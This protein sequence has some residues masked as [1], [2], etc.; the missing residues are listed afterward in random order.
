MEASPSRI[1]VMGWIAP[2]AAMAVLSIAISTSHPLFALLLERSGASGS[3]IGINHAISALAMVIAALVLPAILGRTGLMPLMLWSIVII[4]LCMAV[5]PV[6]G[7]YWWYALLRIGL[8]FAITAMFFAS[9]FWMISVVPDAI[10]GRVVGIYAV[11]LS[12]SYMVGPKLVNFFGI[13]GP[14][15]YIAITAVVLAGA[16][17]VLLGHGHAPSTKAE[18]ARPP[19]AL[20]RFFRTDP[21]VMW[22]VILFG[23]IEFGAMGL[24]AV[25]G[26][27]SGLDQVSAV[28]LVF[29]LA[30]GSMVFQLP[31]GWAADRMDR[32][33]LLALCGVVAVA[34]PLLVIA[35]SDSFSWIAAT[36][37]VWG[38]VAVGLYTIALTE[39][40]ARYQGTALADANAAV[41][42]GYGLG[43]L[44]APVLLG[45]A[46][47][48]IPP[49]G[50][51]WA[52]ML[53]A[54]A[55][56]TL[57]VVR[58]AGARRKTP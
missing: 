9:E 1:S 6:S 56:C 12:G 15:I 7:N 30:F 13:D 44:F 36:I 58:L 39:L 53:A 24:I 2:I 27:R 18:E 54:V 43:A 8:G 57:A 14:E 22:G 46:M 25:W 16:L 20:L 3:A 38:G 37:F 4:A 34:A 33:R 28:D 47:D 50:V 21:M 10:R 11:I 19:L 42:L 17:P 23:V 5:I 31:V 49:D 51:L 45:A 41:V 55:Y 29:W 35:W 26:V 40:G 48:V 32:R 52:A